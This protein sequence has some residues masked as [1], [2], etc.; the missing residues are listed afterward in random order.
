M[1]TDL[2]LDK[3]GKA[4]RN[5]RLTVKNTGSHHC[6]CQ[7]GGSIN[8]L[9]LMVLLKRMSPWVQQELCVVSFS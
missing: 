3:P 2:L 8:Q 9:T 7:D 1:Q 5:G 4:V 6:M